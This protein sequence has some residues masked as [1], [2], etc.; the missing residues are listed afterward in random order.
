MDHQRK[1]NDCAIRY[2]PLVDGIGDNRIEFESGD[3][4]YE[5]VSEDLFGLTHEEFNKHLDELREMGYIVDVVNRSDE[6][7]VYFKAGRGVKWSTCV[8]DL[9]DPIKKAILLQLIEN[10][11]T[12][13][14]LFNTQKGKARLSAE[15]INA[16][17]K[18]R[19][20]KI[21]TFVIVTNDTTL[22]DQTLESYLGRIGR[23]GT[24]VVLP[25]GVFQLSSSHGKKTIEE[26]IHYI[27]AYRLMPDDSYPM[28]LIL[29]LPNDKQIEKV[30]AIMEHVRSRHSSAIGTGGYPLCFSMILDEVDVVYPP[31]RQRFTPYLVDNDIGLHELAFVSATDGIL[32]DDPDYPE[33]ANALLEKSRLD[34]E[35]IPFYRAYHTKDAIHKTV[36]CPKKSSNNQIALDL[37]KE[38]DSYWKEVIA[39][40]SGPYRRKI[41]INSNAKGEDMRA[42]ATEVIGMGYHAMVF[43]QTGL[44]LYRQNN[45]PMRI[46]TKG[47][48]FNELLFYMYKRFDLNSKPLIILGRKKVDRGLGF[49]YAPRRGALGSTTFEFDGK[50]VVYTDGIEGLIWTDMFLGYIENKDTAV[51]KAGRLA[52]I[53]AH[54]PNYTGTL[55]WWVEEMTGKRVDHHNKVVDEVNELAGC[56]TALQAKTVVEAKHVAVPGVSSPTHTNATVP[57]LSNASKEAA[58]TRCNEDDFISEWSEWFSTEEAAMKWWKEKDPHA[59]PRRLELDERGF[60]PCSAAQTRVQSMTDIQK[61]RDG[62]KTTNMPTASKLKVG[63]CTC[64][65]YSAYEIVDDNTTARFCVHWIR[66]ERDSTPV[67]VATI[68]HV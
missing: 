32:L 52:G 27:D 26:I 17:Q 54:C 57:D 12:R 38:H 24:A 44:T 10:P 4:M 46:R 62:K 35:D 59:K 14:I 56:H 19:S 22:G 63:E 50:G 39:L 15:K 7:G 53:I 23:R 42:F 65:R 33:C 58:R 25:K 36:L 41:I 34:E 67:S 20:K 51:Q 43:N 45:E 28:P 8:K 30:L 9:V 37:L 11:K 1:K 49:H 2:Q 29:S 21:V 48:R 60:L 61:L 55:T 5:T 68:S 16:W 66:R 47:K 40:P 31:L 64:R 6:D 18:D 13:F 3:D